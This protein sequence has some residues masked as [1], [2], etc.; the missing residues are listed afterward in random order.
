MI[1][2]EIWFRVPHPGVVS[3]VHLPRN[4]T[5]LVTEHLL[6]RQVLTHLFHKVQVPVHEDDF[7]SPVF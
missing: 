3:S 4:D 6:R 5:H 7:D 2:I 1:T